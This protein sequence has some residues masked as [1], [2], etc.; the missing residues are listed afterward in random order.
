MTMPQ[1]L[2]SDNYDAAAVYS[3]MNISQSMPKQ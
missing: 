1:G 2:S 3:G